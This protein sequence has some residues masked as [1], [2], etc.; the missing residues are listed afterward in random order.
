MQGHSFSKRERQ[1]IVGVA[2]ILMPFFLSV[3]FRVPEKGKG[4]ALCGLIFSIAIMFKFFSDKM[5]KLFSRLI[6]IKWLICLVAIPFI[7]NLIF[8]LDGHWLQ[9]TMSGVLPA[10]ITVLGS[11]AL[12]ILFT[13][14]MWRQL[15][16]GKHV[17]LLFILTNLLIGIMM[18]KPAPRYYELG[19]WTGLILLAALM[20]NLKAQQL[21]T[22]LGALVAVSITSLALNSDYAWRHDL[23]E[24][25][26]LK[27]GPWKESSVDFLPKQKLAAMLGAKGC[28]L[29]AVKGGDPRI[30][31]ALRFLSYGD[32]PESDAICPWQNYRVELKELTKFQTAELEYLNF[33][34]FLG[35]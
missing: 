4:F 16:D 20:R 8:Y 13:I 2:L 1:T 10:P 19:L 3:A 11:V 25:V 31:T 5:L 15:V 6:W 29:S 27:F 32:W 17:V 26:D 14:V 23:S 28:H 21:A 22:C 30:I 33:R 9:K 34:I 18:L 12:L 35:N 7:A 24:V